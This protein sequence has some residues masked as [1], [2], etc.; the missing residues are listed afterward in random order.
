MSSRPNFLFI[1]TDQQRAD[2]LGCAG[3]SILQTPHI[4]ALA[5]SGVQFCRA[6]VNNPL[7]MPARST[8]FTGLTPRGHRVRT[9]GMPLDPRTPTVPQALHSAGYRT[10]SVGKLH[11]R[12]FETPNGLDPETL[13]PEEYAESQ[14]MWRSGRLQSLPEGYYGFETTEF[15]GGHGGYVWGDYLNWLK[16]EHPDAVRLLS[17]E[18]GEKPASC[19]EQSYRMALPAELHFNTWVADRTIGFLEREARSDRPFFLWC[20]FPD[21]H[22]PYCPPRPWADMYRPEDV[23]LPTRREGELDDLPPHFLRIYEEYMPLSG[24]FEPTRIRNDQMRD[25][26]ALTYGMA[27]FIDAQVGRVLHSLETLGLRENTVVVFLSDHGDMMGDHWLL[28]KGPFHF[29]GL[30]RVP[31]IWSWPGHFQAGAC[32][33]AL[34]SHLDVPVTVL[35]LAGVPIPEGPIPLE[36]EA[37]AMSPPWPGQSLVP[38]LNG[39]A[40]SVQSSLLVEND[41][42]YLGLRL[43]TLITDRY[44]ITAYPG[45]PY[46]ELFDMERDP[47]Q[48]Y[49]LWD[50]PDLQALKQD[51]L[52]QLMERLVLTDSALPRRLAHA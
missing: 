3:N 11:M 22:H 39:H 2:H 34:A 46:G 24:R 9:N 7:C 1:V 35:Q 14:S 25:I 36:P 52:V 48:V 33:D 44:Q 5:R 32:T 18:A 41:E 26:I 27:S 28:N 51:L 16:A 37:P 17:A 45:Q 4:D 29:S 31:L 15:I 20:S 30:L 13:N 40:T 49:N 21:P 38:I 12:T 50:R 43:R 23:Q 8:L 47:H 6:H 42:D 10:H 19:A